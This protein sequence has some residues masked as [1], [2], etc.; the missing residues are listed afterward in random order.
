MK[1]I[2]L[3]FPGQGS[4]YIGMGKKLYENYAT[5]REVFDEANEALGFDL[6]ELCFN[7]DINELTKTE[8]TQPAILTASVAAF[9]VYMEKYAIEPVFL[10]GHSLGEFSALTCSGAISFRDAIRIVRN[11]GRFM[12]EAVPQG[13]GAMAAISGVDKSALED[14]CRKVSDENHLVVLSN[15]NSTDQ[16][17]ISGHASSV[18]AASEILKKSGARVVPLKVSAPF[19]SPL[20]QPAA[21]RLKEELNSYSYNE[22]KWDVISNATALPYRGQDKIIENLTLQ[23][24]SPVRWHESMKFLESKGIDMAIELGPQ[25]VLKNLM[26]RNV[27]GIPALSF[28]NEEDIPALERKLSDMGK[29]TEESKGKGLKLLKMCLAT[30]VCTKNTNWDEKEY[31]KG[32][33]EPYRKIQKMKEELEADGCEPSVEQLKEAVE[34]L[35]SVFRTKGIE[36][37]EQSERFGTIFKETGFENLFE[38]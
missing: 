20:M 16:I 23:I 33:V 32:V 4:Q 5:A 10:A 24:V 6:K 22:L 26:K 13:I 29:N 28:D 2:A 14:T 34:M 30:V 3:L 17:V 21:D 36:L 12:Q 31:A 38:M 18:N 37:G 15:H 9:R 35:K 25:T 8:N 7:G 1:R 19:H 27:P 11:R